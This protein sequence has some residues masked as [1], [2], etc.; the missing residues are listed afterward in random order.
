MIYGEESHG[1]NTKDGPEAKLDSLENVAALP[2]KKVLPA[3]YSL[4][5]QPEILA[6]MREALGAYFAMHTIH[7]CE[8]ETSDLVRICYRRGSFASAA[9]IAVPYECTE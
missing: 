4:D 8:R 1:A 7:N 3:H 6:C 5:M 2:V 9:D